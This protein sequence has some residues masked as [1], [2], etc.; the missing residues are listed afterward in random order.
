MRSVRPIGTGRPV[1]AVAGD[2]PALPLLEIPVRGC[3]IRSLP[4]SASTRASFQV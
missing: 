3:L 4:I 2:D 1:L